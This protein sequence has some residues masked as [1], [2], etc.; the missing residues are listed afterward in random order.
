MFSPLEKYHIEAMVRGPSLPIYIIKIETILDPVERSGVMPVERPT[1]ANALVISN[2]I[3]VRLIPGSKIEIKSDE[4]IM[5]DKARNAIT[6]A[7]LNASFGIAY[8]N[9]FSFLFV[10]AENMPLK[11][12][13][14]VVVF[15][16]PPVDPGEAP[17]NIKIITAKRPAFEKPSRENVAKPA[18]LDEKLVNIAP[19]HVML[20]PS[21]SFIKRVPRTKRTP[22]TDKTTFACIESFLKLNFLVQSSFMTRNPIPPKKIRNIVTILSITLSL[23]ADKLCIFPKI[24]NPELLKVA[25]E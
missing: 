1:V 9:A 16:P 6:A 2:R 5:A 25:I 22:L 18:V 21:V 8:R 24:S 19:S 14:N 3:L 11:M 10:A 13:K 20:F 4:A 23:Y 17:M 7:F 12:T 15:I